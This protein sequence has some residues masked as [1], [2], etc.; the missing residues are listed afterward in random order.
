MKLFY[1]CPL[2]MGIILFEFRPIM[3]A[4]NFYLLK[5][6]ANNCLQDRSNLWLDLV[7]NVS[8]PLPNSNN[9]Y[10]IFREITESMNITVRSNMYKKVKKDWKLEPALSGKSIRTCAFLKYDIALIPIFRLFA[11]IGHSCPIKKGKRLIF[12][13]HISSPFHPVFMPGC[14]NLTLEW[15]DSNKKVITCVSF[16]TLQSVDSNYEVDRNN[17]Y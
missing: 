14:W 16:V 17:C 9:Y 8:I 1:L 13:N 6:T 11:E 4:F 2:L 5:A 7:Y 15:L 3:T 10:T 12:N